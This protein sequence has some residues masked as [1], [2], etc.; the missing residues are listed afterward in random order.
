V[1]FYLRWLI[2]CKY[3]SAE[4]VNVLNWAGTLQQE[5][6]SSKRQICSL[7]SASRCSPSVCSFR[8]WHGVRFWCGGFPPS[9]RVIMRMSVGRGDSQLINLVHGPIVLALV[10]VNVW[11]WE[12]KNVL[13]DIKWC[14]PWTCGGMHVCTCVPVEGRMCRV[15]LAEQTNY[16]GQQTWQPCANIAVRTLVSVSDGSLHILHECFNIVV[17]PHTSLS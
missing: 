3:D 16:I 14:F 7:P 6:W 2:F 4:L 17:S 11:L 5:F 15:C 1:Y 8:Q 12:Q 9:D 10:T 13:V